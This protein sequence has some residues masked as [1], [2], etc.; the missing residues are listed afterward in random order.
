MKEFRNG[1]HKLYK[2]NSFITFYDKTDERILYMF[3]N[4]REILK[5][6]KKECNR[7]NVNRINVEIYIALK[8]KGH[9]TRFL[10]GTLMR[11]YIINLDD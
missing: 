3:D 2:G 9:F 1:T 8:R 11:L 7:T 6:Q 4:V 10:N 5:F